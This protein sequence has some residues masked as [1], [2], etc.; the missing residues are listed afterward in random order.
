VGERPQPAAADLDDP[1]A[2]RGV[3]GGQPGRLGRILL[4]PGTPEAREL[5][6]LA[7]N[8]MLKRGDV[9]RIESAGGGGWGDPFARD[10]A[11]VAR[12]VRTGYVSIEAARRDYGVIVDPKT[13]SV[14]ADATAACRSR[15]AA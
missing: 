15:P 2:G 10:P 5:P 1:V 9:I 3:A 4:N 8:I 12:D 6:T 11:A 14:D 13:L 7:D